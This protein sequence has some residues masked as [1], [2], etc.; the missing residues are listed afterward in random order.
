MTKMKECMYAS[1]HDLCNK[2][3]L[4]LGTIT[5]IKRKRCADCPMNPLLD[6]IADTS[7][8][9]ADIINQCRSATTSAETEALS[10]LDLYEKCQQ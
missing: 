5:L 3:A 1:M 7:V 2:L 10:R 8:A 4:I 6:N 9:M